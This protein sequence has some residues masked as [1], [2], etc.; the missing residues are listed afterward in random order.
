MHFCHLIKET[1]Y[2]EQKKICA[3]YGDC[4]IAE[5]DL[6]KWFARFRNG[7]FNLKNQARSK[8]P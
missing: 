8:K 5:F 7:N 1:L 2:K 3:T 4:A 6:R